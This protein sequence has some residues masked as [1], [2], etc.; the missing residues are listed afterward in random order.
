MI[1]TLDVSVIVPVFNEQAHNLTALIAEIERVMLD[2]AVSFEL[3]FVDDGS[4]IETNCFL[5]EL[6]EKNNFIKLVVL[7][8]NFGEQAAICAGLKYCSGNVSVNMDS[9]LQDPPSLIKDMLAAI[10]QGYQVVLA[11]Q[12]KRHESPLKV[13]TSMIFYRLVNFM[14]DRPVPVD[15]G[16]F[17]MLTRPVIDAVNQMPE[18]VRFLRELVPWMGFKQLELPFTRAD[19]AV[20]ESGYTLTKLVKLALQAVLVSSTKPLFFILPLALLICFAAIFGLVL[21]FTSPE[22]MTLT[23]VQLAFINFSLSG[24]TLLVLGVIAP[25]LARVIGEVRSRTI[26]IVSELVGFTGPNELIKRMVS[27]QLN[28]QKMTAFAVDPSERR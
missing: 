6:V 14:A 18:R 27:Q 20:G 1:M 12:V 2:L 13:F 24:I 26:F 25:Y 4:Q 3:V 23:P 11:K 19:R 15:V 17:R 22:V 7:S 21:S 8:R 9:D 10:H 28:E 16:E 5:R